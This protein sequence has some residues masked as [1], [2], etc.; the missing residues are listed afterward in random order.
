VKEK[1]ILIFCGH[2]DDDVLGLGGT[3]RK[4]A[5]E[6][7][8]I[9]EVVFANGN[10]GY[11]KLEDKDRIVDIRKRELAAAGEV[12][13]ISNYELFDYT[14]YGIPA[15]DVTYKLAMRMI[16][17]YRPDIIFCHYWLDYMAHKSVATVVT[18]AW[19]QA[20][21]ESSMELG[22]PWKADSLY[23][24][25]VLGLLPEVSHVVDITDTFDTKVEALKRYESQIPVVAGMLQRAE[26]TAKLRG[27]MIGAL[28]GE[29]LLSSSFVQRKV[30]S[31]DQ[32]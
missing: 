12:L 1:R 11:S 20:G 14:D 13:G 6:G 9:T 26:G 24:F 8:E 10:E 19:W 3:I 5:N 2:P 29:A 32:L 16:R 28:Y 18:E 15:N 31:V 7:A 4:F 22:E 23:Y 25:E 27:S 30:D 21:W 17:K